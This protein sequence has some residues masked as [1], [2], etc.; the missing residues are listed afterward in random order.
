MEQKQPGG[1]YESDPSRRH[2]LNSLAATSIQ[3]AKIHRVPLYAADYAENDLEHSAMLGLVAPELAATLYPDLDEGLIRAYSLVHDLVELETGDEP[4]LKLT[5]RQRAI[6]KER[7]RVAVFEL[8]ARLP[9]LRC[10]RLLEYESQDSKEARF[11]CAVDKLL[12]VTTDL[13]MAIDG[14]GDI[15]RD[16]ME[17]CFNIKTFGEL[18][19][20]NKTYLKYYEKKFGDEFPELAKM[21][22]DQMYEFLDG[23]KP[24]YDRQITLYDL[25]LE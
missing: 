8:A 19:K 5:A 23:I 13:E 25:G 14:R 4:S 10:Q 1:G 7:E 16:R 21:F 20:T 17:E 22:R 11:V 6:K 12:P 3:F 9:R 2:G 15:V 18:K 24:A